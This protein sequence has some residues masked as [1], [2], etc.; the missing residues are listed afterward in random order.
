M[1]EA[2]AMME[3]TAMPATAMP[4]ATAAGTAMTGGDSGK[5]K[6]VS[7][8]PRTG[9]SSKQTDDVVAGIKMSLEERGNKAGNFTIEY[10]DWDDASATLGKW[11]PAVE[12]E[13][14][15]K[16]INDPD[17][18]VYIGTFNS[19]AA[20]ISIPLLNQAGMAMISPANTA[21]ELTK[22]GFDD[23]TLK[24]LYPKSPRNYFRVIVAD[25]VQGAAA[26]NWAQKLGYKKAYIINDQETY[27][28]GVAGVFEKQFKAI[29]GEVLANEGIDYKQPEFRALMSKVKEAG[30]DL[31]YFGGLIETGGP[32]LLKDLRATDPNIGFMGPDGIQTSEFPKSA[33]EENAEGAYATVGGKDPKDLQ[34]KGADFFTKFQAKMGHEADPYSIFGYEAMNV[35]L[36]AI[37]KAGKKDRSAIMEAIRSTKDYDGALGKWSFDE[38]GDTTLSDMRGFKI[39]AGKFVFQEYLSIN[40]P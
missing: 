12:A 23:T 7:S 40:K 8:L 21:P 32:Q 17:I 18:M 3:A 26:A 27:G 19:G 5:I 25:D 34:G 37:A 39:M 20:K 24:S 35:T 13:N 30:A 14:A 10:A 16:A 22:P 28:K 29:G 9:A 1:T 15:N 33:G 36:D 38:N 31:V 2:T 4:E 11:D 6:I